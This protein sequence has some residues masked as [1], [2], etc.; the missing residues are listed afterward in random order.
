MN[1]E[2]SNNLYVKGVKNKAGIRLLST[3]FSEMKFKLDRLDQ[4]NLLLIN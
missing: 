1:N 2:V 4:T 3:S